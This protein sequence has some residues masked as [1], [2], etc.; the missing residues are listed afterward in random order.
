MRALALVLLVAVIVLEGCGGGGDAPFTPRTVVDIPPVV[1]PAP[2]PEPEP[3]PPV[4]VLPPSECT[5]T[6]TE[7][8]DPNR[9]YITCDGVP[10]THGVSYPYDAG[11]TAIAVIDILAVVDTALTLEMRKNLL[12]AE[13]VQKQFDH[14]NEVFANSAVYIELR[15]AGVTMVDVQRGD[16]RRQYKVFTESTWEFSNLDQL[17]QGAGADYAFLF[18][19]REENAIACGVA[20]LDAAREEFNHRRGITQC[21][22][23]DE[24]NDTEATRYYERAGETFIHEIGHMLGLEHDSAS[25]TFIP[26]Y[27]FSYGHLLGDSY[28]TVMSYSDKGAELFS[29]PD[30]Y[31]IIPETGHS[32]A[33]G[34]RRANAVAHLNRVRYYM[35]QLHEMGTVEDSEYPDTPSVPVYPTPVRPVDRGESHDISADEFASPTALNHVIVVPKG[36][37]VSSSFVTSDDPSFG[38]AFRFE[39]VQTAFVSSMRVWISTTPDGPEVCGWDKSYL[40]TVAVQQGPA[41]R[42]CSLDTSTAYF[43]NMKHIDESAAATSYNRKTT[44]Q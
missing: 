14:A 34:G 17:Q 3:E 5:T 1:E 29:D 38:A 35:S 28:G 32:V 9:K 39:A 27:A 20:V 4:V 37:A 13:F 40:F 10:S 6:A 19:A 36:G 42:G 24:F 23:G 44:K 33:L 15:L 22:Q 8:G 26:I 30:K 11:S 2:A 18:K 31:F 12:V 25:A 21:F 41:S 43:I 16:L 7:T